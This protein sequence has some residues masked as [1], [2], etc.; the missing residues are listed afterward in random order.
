MRHILVVDDDPDVAEVLQLAL[1][2]A[3]FEVQTAAQGAEALRSIEKRRPAL[4]LLDLMMPVMSGADLIALLRSDARYHD[5]P[6]VLVTAWPSEAMGVSGAQGVL[7]KPVDLHQLLEV[8]SRTVVEG[9]QEAPSPPA[10]P[11]L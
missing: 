9:Q 3:G 6:V 8:I 11:G 7:C 5:L 4:V 2:A 10:A 1:E